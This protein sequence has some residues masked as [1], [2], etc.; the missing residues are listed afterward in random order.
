MGSSRKSRPAVKS[1]ASSFNP[2]FPALDEDPNAAKLDGWIVDEEEYS[3][4]DRRLEEEGKV[5]LVVGSE[6]SIRFFGQ[7]END[8]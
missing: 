3:A 2:S 6:S 1:P 8:L 7:Q 5:I 4:L